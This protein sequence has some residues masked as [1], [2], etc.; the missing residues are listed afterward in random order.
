VKKP[1]FYLLV[2]MMVMVSA[3][4][5]SP[6]V[7]QPT[8][9]ASRPDPTATPTAAQP[10][11]PLPPTPVVSELV[12]TQ[13]Y[14]HT[15]GQF[16][17]NYPANWQYTERLDGVIFI[18]PG[19]HAG[20]SVFF[21]D[22]G[23]VYSPQQLNQYLVTFVAKNFVQAQ[24]GFK[25]VSQEQ[26]AD[27][28]VKGQFITTDPTLGPMMNEIRVKQV[29]TVVLVTLIRVI[30]PQ[31]EVSQSR[32]EMLVDTLR[33]LETAAASGQ[34]PT[35]ELP[36]W[37]LVGPTGNR[38]A[39]FYPSDWNITHQDE[40]SVT[41][42]LP[43]NEFTFEAS[44]FEWPVNTP[45]AAEKAAQAYVTSLTKKYKDV[46]HTSVA[47]FPL[48]TVK[49]GATFDFLYTT[50]NKVTLAGSVV[51]AVRE[52]QM[53][54]VVFTAPAQFYQGA[55]GWFNPMIKSFKMLTPEKVN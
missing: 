12:A 24:S 27:G 49:D 3:C 26:Q 37:Q 48:D 14:T 7:N 25:A 29:K 21:Y 9:R 30:Q 28:S 39:F 8:P 41:V 53:Y 40:S 17:L 33:P 31:W 15:S 13:S 1:V 38:F 54:R 50:A 35:A 32:L 45:D 36:E 20:Y 4:Q 51:T 55:L 6:A 44:V 34:T 18:E 42:A 46:Q 2:F 16:T 52:G 19:D 23:Q 10:N 22:V 47:K 11:R 43:E 5:N